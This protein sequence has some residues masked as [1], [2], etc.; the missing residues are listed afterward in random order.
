VGWN[1]TNSL[2][3]VIDMPPHSVDFV[4]ALVIY[5]V[6]SVFKRGWETDC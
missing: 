2:C 5:V 3:P 6:Q 4:V 1:G